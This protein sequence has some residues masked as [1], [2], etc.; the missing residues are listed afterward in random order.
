MKSFLTPSRNAARRELEAGNTV[1]K[2]SSGFMLYKE[3]INVSMFIVTPVFSIAS[4][5]A[6]HKFINISFQI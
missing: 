6:V 4:K 1:M 2:T 5:H 3:K